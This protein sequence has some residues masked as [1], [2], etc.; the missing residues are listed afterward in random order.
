MDTDGLL[1]R[2]PLTK[3]VPLQ[4]ASDTVLCTQMDQRFSRHGAHPPAVELHQ[5]LRR[6]ENFKDLPLVRL[7]I[8]QYFVFGE[9]D[10][11]LRLAGWIADHTGEIADQKNHM[12]SEFLKVFEF[13]DQD[14]MAKMQ[15]SLGQNE[16]GFHT[17]RPLLFQRT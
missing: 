5:S 1:L 3:I 8:L 14:S 6:I 12:M 4:H 7:G 17:Q 15:I 2:V 10:A 13:V 9:R 11:G 16:A